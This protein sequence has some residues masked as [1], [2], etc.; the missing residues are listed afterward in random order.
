[1]ETELFNLLSLILTFLSLVIIFYGAKIAYN[2]YKSNHEWN[3]RK[4]TQEVLRD[5]VLGDYPKFSKIL[6]DNNIKPFNIDETYSTSLNAILDENLKKDVIFATKNVFNLFEFIAINIKNNTIDEDIC[7]DYLGWM[8]TQYYRWGQDYIKNEQS[9]G[10]DIRI[11]GNFVER[12]NIWL[13]RMEIE[14][15]PMEIRGKEK[16]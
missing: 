9:K 16:L 13:A 1:M 2:T 15:K 4:S 8:Y 14:K 6:L 3:R 12:A 5:L 10:N 11:L 7:Y